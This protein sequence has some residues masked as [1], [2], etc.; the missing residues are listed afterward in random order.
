MAH[1]SALPVAWITLRILIMLNWL[2][3]AAI[4]ALLTAMIVAEQWTFTALGDMVTPSLSNC[5]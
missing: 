3:G 4:L 5:V 2:S 1:S